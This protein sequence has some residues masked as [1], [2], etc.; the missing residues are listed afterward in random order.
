MTDFDDVR[1][2]VDSGF[3]HV[4]GKYTDEEMEAMKAKVLI[5]ISL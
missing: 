4:L 2:Y 1:E 5:I 3:E